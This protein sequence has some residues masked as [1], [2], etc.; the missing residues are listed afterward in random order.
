MIL[1]SFIFPL[2]MSHNS[3]PLSAS[4]LGEW[5]VVWKGTLGEQFVGNSRLSRPL[6]NALLKEE[7]EAFRPDVWSGCKGTTLAKFN[8]HTKTWH[9][10]YQDNRGEYCDF[11]G[12]YQ[13]RMFSMNYVNALGGQ[14][15]QRMVVQSVHTHTIRWDC[16]RYEAVTD[17]WHKVWEVKYW[18]Q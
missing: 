18:R 4:W 10:A 11:I 15:K 12:Q 14:I 17:R 5:Q 8:M 6:N 2:T 9:Y 1:V 16:E 13:G 3:S 7:I